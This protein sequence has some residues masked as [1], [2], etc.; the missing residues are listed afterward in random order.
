MSAAGI[1]GSRV[2][3]IRMVEV[4]V[5][6]S[7]QIQVCFEDRTDRLDGLKCSMQGESKA[8]PGA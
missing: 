7:G 1:P 8:G 2:G 4:E 5:L 6:L 3:W